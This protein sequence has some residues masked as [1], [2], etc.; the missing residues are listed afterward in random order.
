LFAEFI[1]YVYTERSHL[2]K[3]MEFFMSCPVGNEM[4]EVGIK[5]KDFF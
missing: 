5:E 4:L 1:A 2:R 3:E